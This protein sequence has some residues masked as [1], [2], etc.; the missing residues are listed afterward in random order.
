M[1]SIANVTWSG[2][3]GF[4]GSTAIP[5]PKGEILAYT[6]DSANHRLILWNSTKVIYNPAFLDTWGP[7][8]GAVYDG[9][10]GIEWNVSIP[11]VIPGTSLQEVKDG[12]A[13]AT[14]A[15]SSVEPAT[16]VD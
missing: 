7:T 2:A 12:Y 8:I 11:A 6:L 16:H 1:C 14:Y 5:G 3:G 4:G 9:R 13:L 15:D 10:V